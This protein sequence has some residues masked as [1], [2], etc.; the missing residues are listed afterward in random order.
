MTLWEWPV[1]ASGRR[2]GM[3]GGFVVKTPTHANLVQ[4]FS[5]NS[6]DAV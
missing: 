1:K 6:S 5:Q 4:P 3:L 2:T